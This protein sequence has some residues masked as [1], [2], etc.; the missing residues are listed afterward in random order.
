MEWSEV[1]SR[2]A[3]VMSATSERECEALW[4][5][6]EQV[7]VD[8]PIVEV[9]TWHGRTAAVLAGRGH[10]VVSVDP[11]V[12]YLDGDQRVQPP[13]PE[14]VRRSVDGTGLGA[15]VRLVHTAS[16]AAAASWEGGPIGM[17]FV[18]GDHSRPAVEADLEAWLPLMAPGAVVAFHDYLI[19]DGWGDTR[20]AGVR[21]AV[22]AAVEAGR[23]PTLHQVVERLAWTRMPAKRRKR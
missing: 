3:H 23:L 20:W 13:S 7:P 9:G 4:A 19:A 2:V 5:L 10:Q 21:Q 14:D 1:R 6:T 16:P 15:H 22:D 17:L 12:A 8:L 11:L 18:D